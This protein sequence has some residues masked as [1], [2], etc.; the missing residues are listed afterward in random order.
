MMAIKEQAALHNATIVAIG[1]GTCDQAKQFATQFNFTGE[2]YLD[3]ELHSYKAF[4]L[5]RGVFKTIGPAS[6]VK[7]FKTLG[8]GFRQGK[9]AGDLWQQGGLFVLGPGDQIVYEHRDKVA[10]DLADMN[11]V[12]GVCPIR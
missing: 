10:G 4:G 7:G 12:I 11:S 2:L 5:E 8:K 3:P 9:H 6:I 1:S